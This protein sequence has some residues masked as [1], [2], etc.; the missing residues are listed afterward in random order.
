MYIFLQL[1]KISS[2]IKVIMVL[3]L[4]AIV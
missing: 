4:Q 1:A 3:N 2:I